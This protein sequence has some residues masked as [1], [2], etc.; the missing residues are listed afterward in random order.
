MPNDKVDD[1]QSKQLSAADPSIQDALKAIPFFGQMLAY[2]A[3]HFGFVSVGAV[4]WFIVLS[5]MLLPAL[6]ALQ[7]RIWPEDLKRMYVHWLLAP[8]SVD[9]RVA[10]KV[11]AAVSALVDDN[12][13]R[14]DF[15]Q[16]YHQLWTKDGELTSPAYTFPLSEHQEFNLSFEISNGQPVSACTDPAKIQAADSALNESGLFTIRALG[17]EWKS[18]GIAVGPTKVAFG[19]NSWANAKAEI[20]LLRNERVAS[21]VVQLNRKEAKAVLECYPIRSKLLI[22]VKKTIKARKLELGDATTKSAVG[23]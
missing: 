19:E 20:D 12:N 9:Q 5:P 13:V 1:G 15:V 22:T 7:L 17:K 2:F 16:Q 8:L 3:R 18:D 21:V 6:M 4:L 10:D 14:L 11:D 23:K